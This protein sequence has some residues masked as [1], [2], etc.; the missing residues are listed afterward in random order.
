MN[1]FKKLFG[2]KTEKKSTPAPRPQSG[3]ERPGQGRSRSYHQ[4]GQRPGSGSGPRPQGGS[5]QRPGGQPPRP[6]SGAPARPEPRVQENG[7]SRPQGGS[8]RSRRRRRPRRPQDRPQQPAAQP[9][10]AVQPEVTAAPP[11]APAEPREIAAAEPAA[12]ERQPKEPLPEISREQLSPELL[13]GLSRASWEDLMPVQARTI[14]YLLAR[15]DLM[16]QSRT[17]SGKTGAFI[18]PM[19]ERLDSSLPET[20]ALVLVPTRELAKQV[21]GEAQMLFGDSGLRVTAVYGGVG[22][23]S[24][25]DAFREGA[26][27]VVGTPGRILDHLLKGSLNLRSLKLLILDEADR[28]LSMGFYPDMKEVQQYLP[29]GINAYMFSATFPP[30]VLH[31]AAEFLEEPELISLSGDQV[32]VAETEHS[33]YVVPPMDKDRALVR[34][35]EMENPSQAIVFCNTRS[36]VHYVA[37]VLQ[38]FGYNADELSSDLPQNAREKVMS[39]LRDGSLR[40]LVATDVAARGIDIPQLPVVI[41]YEPPEDPE[42]YIHRAGRTGRA[43]ASGEAVSLVTEVEQIDLDRIARKFNFTLIS[44][45]LPQNEDVA[46]LV[47][48]RVTALLEAKYRAK[49]NV[50]KERLRR[51]QPLAQSLADN[52][53][54]NNVIAMLLDEFY[55]QTL[56]APVQTTDTVREVRRDEESEGETPRNNRP[57]RRGGRHRRS[58]SRP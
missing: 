23:G 44:R 53:D 15:R 50:E 45:V 54:L 16:V 25:I 46:A 51:F 29:Q 9:Q 24:Q 14:P 58:G 27:L 49:D 22:Y 56:H 5:P 35:I 10:A 28:M 2:S 32:Y 1:L 21:T 47:T 40:F 48:E 8:S 20:Q 33:F 39:R 55:Q 6:Q 18:L 11:A 43:G 13:A 41:M 38:R 30:F 34:I 26:H 37:I 19:L 4:P 12:P 7:E 36:Q 52:D 57:R 17:G 31:L 3:P 42:A